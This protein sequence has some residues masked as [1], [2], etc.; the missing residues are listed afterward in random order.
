MALFCSESL[1]HFK[2]TGICSSIFF[3]AVLQ[4]LPTFIPSVMVLFFELYVVWID[5]PPPQVVFL[6]STDLKFL[7]SLH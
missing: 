7:L 1:L 3:P 2:I 4:F 5:S 6:S